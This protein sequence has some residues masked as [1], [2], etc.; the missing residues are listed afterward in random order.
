MKAPARSHAKV[1]SANG[2][3]IGEVTS[4]GFG[5]SCNKAVAMGYVAAEHAAEGTDVNVQIRD[6]MYPAKVS[7]YI[8]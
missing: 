1:F 2:T 7:Y 4:G 5:P 3:P 6:K 8:L